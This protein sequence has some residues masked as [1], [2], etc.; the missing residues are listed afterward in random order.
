MSERRAKYI[1]DSQNKRPSFDEYHLDVVISRMDGQMINQMKMDDF[2]ADFVD[3]LASKGLSFGGGM[4][5][6]VEAP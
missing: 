2:F 3:F 5:P 6:V 4:N 1:V